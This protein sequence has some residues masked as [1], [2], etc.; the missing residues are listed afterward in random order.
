AL[1]KK[2]GKRPLDYFK[3]FYGDTSV[4]GSAPAIRCGLDFFGPDRVLF[5]TDCPFDPE[6][7]PTFIRESIRA[8]DSL[9]LS[10]A[11]RNKVYYGNAQR[12]LRM[13]PAAA[14]AKR[15]KK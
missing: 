6:G 2:L 12:M 11:V 4:N 9:K 8:I 14:P 7:G 3:M 5:G 15:R 1:L 10:E 13:G